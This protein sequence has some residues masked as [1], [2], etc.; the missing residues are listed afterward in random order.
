MMV[1][2]VVFLKYQPSKRSNLVFPMLPNGAIIGNKLLCITD[3]SFRKKTRPN[4]D[5]LST[6]YV[7]PSKKS[8]FFTEKKDL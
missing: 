3:A 7:D 1:S 4:I 5:L 6:F 8:A 2:K